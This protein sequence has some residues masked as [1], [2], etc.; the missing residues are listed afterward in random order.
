[1]DEQYTNYSY[2]L[3]NT[4]NQD[5]SEISFVLEDLW[6][7]ANAGSLEKLS[8]SRCIDEY[9]TS[10]QSNRRNLLLVSDDDRLPSSTNNYFL[11]GSHVYWYDKFRSED[12]FSPEKTSLKFEWICQNINDKSPP[13]SAMVEDIKKQPWHVGELCYDKENCKPSD[14]PVKYCLSERAEPRCKIHFEP[15]I[16]IV[17]IVL[18]FFKAG[19]MF[20][21]AFCVNDEPLMSMGDAVASFLGKEDIETRNMCLSSMANFRDGKGYK[22]RPRQYSGETY[23]W[24]D[25]T[26]ML[27]RCITLIMFL[28]ALAVVSHL[29]KLGIDNLPAGATLKEFTF[30]AVDPRT[31]VNYRSTDLISNVLTANTPQIILSLLY[32]A[33]NSLFTAMLMGYEWVTYSRNRKGLRVTRQ[34]SGT[35]R[36]T[37]FLQLPYRFGIPLMVLSVTLHWLVSQS[38]FLVAIELYD[39]NGDLYEVNGDLYEVNGYPRAFDSQPDL[40]TLGYSPLAIIAVLALGGLMVISMVAFGYIPYKRGMPLAGTCSLAISAACHPTEQVEGDENIAEKM[41]Q[42]GVVSIGDDEIGHCAF[43]ADEVGAVVKGKLYGGITA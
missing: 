16:A 2:L 19:L 15:S 40:K 9:A 36:S 17:V 12:W 4:Y 38:I 41:L 35:Q 8:P 25:V 33:Y 24:K 31:T 6:N 18:N 42:W 37:Y 10:I 23:R 39:V 20:Y 27:R 14:A 11:N 3:P 22:V 13:C 32:Y 43:S 29:L 21:I 26:S 28:L 34:P 5:K 7:K 1:M 30:G